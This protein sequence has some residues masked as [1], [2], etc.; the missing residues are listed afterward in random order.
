MTV[1]GRMGLGERISAD[2]CV[3]LVH[4]LLAIVDL[5]E[6]GAQPMPSL[7]AHVRSDVNTTRALTRK[8]QQI[9]CV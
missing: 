4:R 8:S 9:P 5:S 3:G 2:G 6:S 7:N 1:R